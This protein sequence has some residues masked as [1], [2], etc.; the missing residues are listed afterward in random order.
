MYSKLV[1]RHEQTVRGCLEKYTAWE[2]IEC[3]L[4]ATNAD[5]VSFCE[6][7]FSVLFPLI[8]KWLVDNTQEIP[9]VMND[10][11]LANLRD[12]CLWTKESIFDKA[13]EY[14]LPPYEEL[15]AREK[16][17]FASFINAKL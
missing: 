5:G 10:E 16:E 1:P 12:D 13:V 4:D 17:I 7:H 3:F 8:N 14:E 15:R 2:D 11:E 6:A 9:Q